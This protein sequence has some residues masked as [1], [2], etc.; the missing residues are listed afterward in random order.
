[1]SH[2]F[3]T[4]FLLVIGCSSIAG[5]TIAQERILNIDEHEKAICAFLSL[6]SQKPDLENW[7]RHSKKYKQAN[8]FDKPLIL[9]ADRTRLA[10]GCDIYEANKDFVTIKEKIR[11]STSLNDQGKRIISLRF[12]DKTKN[13]STYFSYQYGTNSIALIT[14]ELE[15]FRKITLK[16]EEIPLITKH[17]HDNAPYEAEI[18]MRIKPL[19]ADTGSTLKIGGKKQWLMLGDIAYIKINFFDKFKNKNTTIWNYNAP[20]YYNESQKALLEMFK[21]PTP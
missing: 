8:K 5:K 9:K 21:H 7:I 12:A 3:L 19:S 14:Q 17:L 6:T 2:K 10:N 4:I 20:W 11:I 18:E 16:P 15:N 1:L 13:K